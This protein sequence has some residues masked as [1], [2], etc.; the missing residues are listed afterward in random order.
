[1]NYAP[2]I[3]HAPL[4]I[5]FW[6]VFLAAVGH[7]SGVC[8]R[9]IGEKRVDQDAGTFRL[10]MI[11]SP[12]SMFA[13]FAVAF[14][15]EFALP[16]PFAAAILGMICMAGG[17]LL[18]RWCFN[19]LGK[20]FTGV[21]IVRPEQQVIQHGPYRF[22]RHPSYTGGLLMFIGVG[23]GLG[24]WLSLAILFLAH[25]LIYGLRVSAE[26]KAL[27]AT[28][29]SAYSDYMCKTKRFIPFVI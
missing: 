7:E 4:A 10:L 22:V 9:A 25:C 29:G 3:F 16:M 11:G 26:E 1:M 20:Y 12:L 8:R 18:R 14:R 15:P 23:L 2:E 19:T 21:V 24:S 17:A 5:P 28:I 13:A 27:V 6:I